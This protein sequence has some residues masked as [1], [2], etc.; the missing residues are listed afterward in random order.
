M[1]LMA[2]L[3]QSLNTF[4]YLVQYLSPNLNGSQIII[5]KQK[6]QDNI[7]WSQKVGQGH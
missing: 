6:I 7:I 5:K 3:N 4:H 2:N 1:S